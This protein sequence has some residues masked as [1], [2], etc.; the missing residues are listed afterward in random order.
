MILTVPAPTYIKRKPETIPFERHLYQL[1]RIITSRV[2]A[3]TR[4]NFRY[5]FLI[6]LPSDL[7]WTVD[8]IHRMNT[9]ANTS[10]YDQCIPA[11]NT[12]KEISKKSQWL[13]KPRMLLLAEIFSLLLIGQE[14]S[15]DSTFWCGITFHYFLS[16]PLPFCETPQ[17]NTSTSFLFVFFIFFFSKKP[18]TSQT[19]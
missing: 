17:H 1:Q 3:T 2:T 11:P 5:Y 14:I 12:I 8:L 18:F 7:Q 15:Q 19:Q 6:F 16:N 4:Q 13:F 10:N 9:H